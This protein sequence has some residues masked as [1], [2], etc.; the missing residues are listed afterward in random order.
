MT[1]HN[2]QPLH[3]AIIG[4]GISG[5]A[6]AFFI[7]QLAPDSR[8]AIFE[9]EARFGGTM[10]SEYRDGFLFEAGPNGFLS[11]RAQTLDLVRESGAEK[12]LL[13]SSDDARIRYIFTQGLQRLPDT[14]PAF[15]RTGLLSLRDKL[16][17]LG[18]VFIPPQKGHD[19]ETLRAF[20]NRRL[21]RAFTDIFLD[22]MSAGIHASTPDRLS[23]HAAFPAVVTLEREY[24]GLF[25]GMIKKRKKEAGPGG[26]LMSF[27]GGVGAFT[28]HLANTLADTLSVE[29][30]TGSPVTEL[31]RANS[32]YRITI[33]RTGSDT[34]LGIEPKA[35]FRAESV[36]LA[37]P[38]YTSA[39]LMASM[40]QEIA[41]K[42]R[43]ISY[44]P[45]AVVGFSFENIA[46]SLRGF[47]LLTTTSAEQEILGV[48]C[49]SAIFPGRAPEGRQ[50][51]R[52]LIGGQ[53]NPE[54]ALRDESALIDIAREGIKRT[55]HIHDTPSTIFVKRWEQGIPNYPVGHLANVRDIHEQIK[56]YPGLSLNSNAYFGIGI[57]DCV[58]NS[59]ASA[60]QWVNEGAK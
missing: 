15:L 47:G 2:Q 25:R 60:R 55:M 51:L 17:V 18:E 13:K 11:N 44:S 43:A 14:P 41:R 27:R 49:D 37:T 36:I 39:G 12:L 8:I 20:G 33:D 50:S 1:N 30:H 4:G 26:V 53:R 56:A 59:L 3:V 54:L 10:Q 45:V 58:V 6:T 46:H 29:L 16:R 42:L 5:L 21:G 52:V 23:V 31:A 57:N 40:D 7:R 24:G 22:A 48:L 34:K 38:S 9:K 19:D 32:G 28:E 35:E